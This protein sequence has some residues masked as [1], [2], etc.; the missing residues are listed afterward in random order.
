MPDDQS[1]EMRK[2]ELIL[3]QAKARREQ[4]GKNGEMAGK[5][6]G[7]RA[8]QA[9][10]S[11]VGSAVPVVGTALG[12]KIGAV[13]GQIVGKKAG[14]KAGQKLHDSGAPVSIFDVKTA[15]MMLVTGILMFILIIPFAIVILVT[16]VTQSTV[17]AAGTATNCASALGNPLSLNTINCYNS[18]TGK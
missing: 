2:Q 5:E 9:A 8:G 14:R 10:G 17:R 4:A 11:V 18:A 12:G 13:M 16:T 1:Q 6:I 7:K 3:A 15:K